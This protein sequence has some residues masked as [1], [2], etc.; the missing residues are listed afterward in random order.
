MIKD[1]ES[2]RDME[3]IENIEKPWYCISVFS[4]EEF[5]FDDDFKEKIAE[6]MKKKILDDFDGM[7]QIGKYE[8]HMPDGSIKYCADIYI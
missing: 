6:S 1:I 5:K 3:Y 2:P 7:V 4:V 8:Q